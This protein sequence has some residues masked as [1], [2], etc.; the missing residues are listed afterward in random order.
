MSLQAAVESAFKRKYERP[1]KEFDNLAFQSGVIMT[2][3][4]AREEYE[5]KQ[6][7]ISQ[8]KQDIEE[9]KM[10]RVQNKMEVEVLEKPFLEAKILD[11][12]LKKKTIFKKR[13]LQMTQTNTENI[14]PILDINPSSSSIESAQG[15]SIRCSV[16]DIYHSSQSFENAK[17]WQAC[18]DC[19]NWFCGWMRGNYYFYFGKCEGR[20]FKSSVW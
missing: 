5:R 11:P 3:K 10:K 9:N 16:F 2:R 17:L 20:R 19:N 6:T 4:E 1:R 13:R 15:F 18:Y 14:N 7:A 12:K 8:K